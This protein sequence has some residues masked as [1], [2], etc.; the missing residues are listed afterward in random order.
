MGAALAGPRRLAPAGAAVVGRAAPPAARCSTARSCC[1]AAL[2]LIVPGFITDVLGVLA[3]LPP[4]RALM[5]RA[6]RPQPPEPAWCVRRRA[7][8]APRA[9]YDVDSTATDVDQPQLHPMTPHA[10]PL[11]TLAFGDLDADVWGAAWVPAAM[12]G[13]GRARRR[14]R[15]A[16][17]APACA[18][19]WLEDGGEWRLAGDGIELTR[20]RP[21]RPSPSGRPTTRSSGFD[22][23]CRVTAR[24]C[25][26]GA[27]QRGRLPRTASRGRGVELGS[28]RFVRVVSP[29]SR[30][31]RRLALTGA[32]RRGEAKGQDAR[33]RRGH[34]ARPGAAAVPVDDPRLSTTYDAGGR[35]VAR[36]PRA[37]GRAGGRGRAVPAPRRRRGGG[38][39]R[40]VAL[41][42]SSSSEP[43]RPRWHSRGARGRRV[44]V[45][46]RP[47]DEPR[48][49][50]HQR[51]RRRA[52]LAAAGLV[53]R[54]VQ[55]SSGISL[56]ELGKAMAAIAARDG[57]N[58]LFELETGRMTE[59]EFLHC[60]RRTAV[61]PARPPGRAPRLRRALLRPPAAERAR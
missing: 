40:R 36:R 33:R 28:A 61:R 18:C 50:D 1:S 39:A 25:S 10:T 60:A 44:Y 21:A 42:A 8:P 6:A 32:P 54:P 38:R 13:A 3:L 9:P 41:P 46:A 51:L 14:Q 19:R 5:R 12:A 26:A 34:G 53:R 30:P 58:P 48:R 24:S 45:L 23:L 15:V 4:T 35:P 20:R 17:G 59:A 43:S 11:R 49:G 57:T 55:D 29:G 22:Q 56:E 27:E 37:V 2:L 47:R 16:A 52:H 31:T 7:S